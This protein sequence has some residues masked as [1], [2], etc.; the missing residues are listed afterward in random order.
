MNLLFFP[1]LPPTTTPPL[2]RHS[3]IIDPNNTPPPCIIG[4]TPPPFFFSPSS[5]FSAAPHSKNLAKIYHPL[6]TQIRQQWVRRLT[7]EQGMP[8]NYTE[9]K[10]RLHADEAY[11]TRFYAM[12]RGWLRNKLR[13]D[14]D[15]ALIYKVK[16][17]I[18]ARKRRKLQ[19]K[20]KAK[21]DRAG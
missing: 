13:N 6:N 14:P 16:R 9:H 10:A 1:L 7:Q 11:K 8:W 4:Y 12:C 18:Q 2:P 21:N 5:Y 19:R 3:Y 15:Y 20:L 17:R